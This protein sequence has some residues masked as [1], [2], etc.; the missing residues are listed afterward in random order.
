MDAM[1]VWLRQHAIAHSAALAGEDACEW[2]FQDALLEELTEEQLRLRPEPGLNSLAWLLWHMARTEDVVMNLLV[3]GQPQVLQDGDWLHR[4]HVAR[5]DIGTG[6]GDADV[7]RI[8]ASVDIPSLLA[9]RLAVGCR[10]RDII[11]TLQPESLMEPVPAS[12]I[13]D[14]LA[15]GALID[16]AHSLA[17]FWRGKTTAYL[18]AMPATGHNLAHL[19]EAMSI[20]GRLG[21]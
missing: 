16:D 9:Y 21:L 12:R 17:E 13:D 1:D 4:L 10:T 20:R 2:S 7:A 5:S 18:L 19:G 15:A 3:A 8:S 6:A 14:L 11:R